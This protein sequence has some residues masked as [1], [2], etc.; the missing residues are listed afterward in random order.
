[1]AALGWM[2]NLDFAAS[3]VAEAPAVAVAEAAPAVTGGPPLRPWP[4]RIVHV[5]YPDPAVAEFWVIALPEVAEAPA[6]GRFV[7]IA[8]PALL[9]LVEPEAALG[10][11]RTRAPVPSL[12]L[13]EH[14]MKREIRE[15]R[16]QVQEQEERWLLGI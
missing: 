13:A 14:Q 7:A 5:A 10:R 2:L 4:G 3:G 9:L 11:F 12:E 6:V 16:R 1:M 8:H 15:L